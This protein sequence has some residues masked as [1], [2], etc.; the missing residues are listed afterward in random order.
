MKSLRKNRF[1]LFVLLII[2]SSM[3]F[4]TSG[5]AWVSQMYKKGQEME[6]QSRKAG[7]SGFAEVH[8]LI[9][10]DNEWKILPDG[11]QLR[12]KSTFRIQ[13]GYS[14]RYGGGTWKV[15]KPRYGKSAS[16]KLT[17]AYFGKSRNVAASKLWIKRPE[18][19]S[20]I[21]T[22]YTAQADVYHLEEDEWV[23]MGTVQTEFSVKW[24]PKKSLW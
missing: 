20:R 24:V 11:A 6:R 23:L 5:C 21:T 18:G 15:E 1:R 10:S 4:S 22:S 3:G 19:A 9:K 7:P 2:V 12:E 13:L 8:F 16:E 17:N 14:L